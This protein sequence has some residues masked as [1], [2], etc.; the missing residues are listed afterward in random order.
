MNSITASFDAAAPANDDLVQDGLQIR[1]TRADPSAQP[2]PTRRL[3]AFSTLWM[4]LAAV[5]VPLS[6]YV[7]PLYA[8]AFGLSLG[9]V[10]LIFL[11]ARLWDAVIDPGIGILSDR[12]RSRFG[13]RRPWIFAGAWIFAFGAVG[14]FLPPAWFGPLEFSAALFTLYLGY[15]M[16][17]TPYSAWSGELSA[18]YHE[19]TRVAS[20]GQGLM[21][22]ALLLALVVPSLLAQRFAHEPRYQLASMGIMVFVLLAVALPFSLR[23][24]PEPAS[25]APP[26]GER[27]GFWRTT[28]LVLGEKLLIRVLASNFGI[29]LAQG[30]R[31]ALFVFF[32]AHYMG[33][34]AWA[35]ALFLLQYVF[36]IIACPIW[37][38][39]GRRIGKG[40]AAVAGELTQV[41]I[42]F[43][44]LLVTPGAWP[45][46]LLLT[47]SQGLA[48]GSGNL[49]LRAIVADVADS[50]RLKTGHERTG[51][52]YS[53]FSLSDK[54]ALAVAVGIALPL[55]GWLGF[56]PREVNPPEVLEHLK[57]VFA[58]GPVIGHIISASIIH[59]FPLDEKR[60]AEIRDSLTARESGA[61]VSAP[62]T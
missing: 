45:L 30:T 22:V 53:V 54:A 19:R 61:S 24:L 44:L 41:A 36:G 5:E 58:L 37:L 17:A 55:I 1:Q 4:P 57:Y 47:V 2:L 25:T 8:G 11:F 42:N 6:T 46:L 12:T 34:P 49:M 28:S 59:G 38:A 51:L 20:Y 18:A 56:D 26:R 16:M 14:V 10:G 43:A 31:T 13:R 60:H 32:V 7:P 48:Q 9:T 29:R 23:A 52:F 15:S 40:R 27:T 50:H 35:P 33:S 62:T 3:L 39:I 21:S